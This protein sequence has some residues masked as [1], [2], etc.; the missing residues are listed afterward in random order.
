M[1]NLSNLIPNLSN[2][3]QGPTEQWRQDHDD[4]AFLANVEAIANP[5]LVEAGLSELDSGA[6][7]QCDTRASG[8]AGYRTE[9]ASNLIEASMLNGVWP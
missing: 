8:A 9:L 6:I 3:L 7:V 1:P 2:A 5:I 4:D